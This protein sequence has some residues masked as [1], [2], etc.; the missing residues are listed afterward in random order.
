MPEPESIQDSSRAPQIAVIAGE[1][2]G[3]ILGAAIIREIKAR[4]PAA[5]VYGV[6]GPRMIKA[7]CEPIDTIDTLSVM[8]L[9]EVLKELPRLLRFRRGLIQRFARERPDVVVGIDAPDFNLGV[10][11]RLRAQ[12]LRTVHVVSPTVW[13]WRA[14]RV[15]TIARAVDKILCLFP[16]EPSWYAH[17]AVSA[18]YIG[19]PLA[20]ELSDQVSPEDARARLKM[21]TQGL[22]VTVMPGSR[23]GEI[24][25]LAEPFAR[26]ANLLHQQFPGIRFITPVAKPSLRTEITEAIRNFA[27]Q[28][29]WQIVDGDSRAA[30]QAADAVLLASGTATLECLLLGRPMVVAYRASWITNFIMRT[31]G[32]LKTRYVSLPNLLCAEPVVPELLQ[33]GADP[34]NLAN[35]IAPLL[36]DADARARQLAPFSAVRDSLRCNA[37]ARAAQSILACLPTAQ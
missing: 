21:D 7:G 25:Y 6:A 2:S 16:F 29:H 31:L 17:H 37:G 8:G 18:E 19:H 1:I 5:R 33:E 4:E 12:G 13:A 24:R 36:L 32:V 10:E 27:P 34:Q 9:V 20:D 22:V 26:A 23:H 28:C 14:G 30:M 35:H 11:A 15:K 3:D